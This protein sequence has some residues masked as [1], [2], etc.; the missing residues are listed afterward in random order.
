MD[1]MYSSL[2][3]HTPDNLI[4]GNEVPIL[5]KGITLLKNQGTLLRGT[6]VGIVTASGLAVTVDSSKS[7]GSEKAFCILTDDVITPADTDVKI[8]GY[9]SGMFNRNALIFGG[10]DTVEDHE[11]RLREIGIFFKDII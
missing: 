4:A 11:L 7:D 3:T 2:G 5:V 6:V 10:T 9:T 1:Q 8:T